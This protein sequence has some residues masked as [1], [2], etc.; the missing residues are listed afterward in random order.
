MQEGALADVR[1]DAAEIGMSVEDRQMGEADAGRLRGS[2]NAQRHLGRVG[3]GRAV[4]GV[5]QVMEFGDMAEAALQHLHVELGGDRLDVVG[6]HQ[7][8]G[9]VHFFPPG[10][11]TV[12]A[13]AG[14]LGE[15]RHGA[16]EGVGMQIGDGWN[17]RSGNAFVA[18]GDRL[19]GLNGGDAA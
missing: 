9:A 8:D 15:A 11:E 2:E 5:V 12:V 1:G 3:I 4:G 13:A 7:S 18:V 10:P 14:D 6:V 17:E 16:L 19:I